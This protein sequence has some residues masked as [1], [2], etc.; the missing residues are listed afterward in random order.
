MG[1]TSTGD[2]NVPDGQCVVCKQ[3]LSNCSK[4]PVKLRGHLE[5]THPECKPKVRF[6]FQAEYGGIRN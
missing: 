3:A 4:F 5:I 2:I 6:F 1:F